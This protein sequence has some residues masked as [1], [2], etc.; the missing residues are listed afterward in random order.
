VGGR[1]S[2]PRARTPRRQFSKLGDGETICTETMP[3]REECQRGVTVGGWGI[4][5]GDWGVIVEGQGVTAGGWGATV[6]ETSATGGT[7]VVHSGRSL[8]GPLNRV[9]RPNHPQH[10][11]KT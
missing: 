1:G 2:G 8:V 10:P 3:W 7:T 5:V 4:T 6:G 11:R 9:G